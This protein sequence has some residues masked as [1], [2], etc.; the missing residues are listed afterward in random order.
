MFPTP[1]SLAPK[2]KSGRGTSDW[3]SLDYILCPGCTR[4]WA[5][6]YPVFPAS[7]VGSGLCPKQLSFMEFPSQSKTF[8]CWVDK[9]YD[10][11]PLCVFP[12]KLKMRKSQDQDQGEVLREE[13]QKDFLDHHQHERREGGPTWMAIWRTR[14]ACV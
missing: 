3:Q 4:S 11:Y 2:S 7:V 5:R 10:K 6:K 14:R 13:K 12:L 8:R 9:T 1:M